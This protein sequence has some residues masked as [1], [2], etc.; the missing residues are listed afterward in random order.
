MD[1]EKQLN[2]SR[3]QWDNAAA[4]FDNEPDHGLHNPS[5]LAAWTALLKLSLT[6]IKGTVLDIGC[7]TGSLSTVLAELGYQVTGID[8]SPRMLSLAEAKAKQADHQISFYVMDAVFPTLAPQQFDAIVCRHLLWTLPHFDEVL[9][10]W[11]T[12]LKPNGRLLLIEGYWFTGAGLHAEQI[13]EALPPALTDVQVRSLSHQ[14]G[15]WA[16][17]VPDE[18]YAITADLRW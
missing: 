6:D 12:L 14:T 17:E 10:R 5:V 8:L 2:A 4:S 9:R 11:V 15:L 16:G 1:Y 7:G 3:Q 13:V 18:R